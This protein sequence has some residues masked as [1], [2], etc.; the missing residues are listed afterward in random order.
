MENKRLCENCGK[1]IPDDFV[2]NLCWDCY[3]RLSQ[4]KEKIKEN[5]EKPK[6]APTNGKNGITEENYY[7]NPEAED[8]EQWEAN[9]SL[10][11]KNKIMLWKSTRQIYT[12][13]KNYNL[14]KII[15]H[16]QYPKFIWKPRIVD[17]GCGIGLG[18]NVLSQEADFVWG[19]DKNLNSI[20]FAKE[21]FERL[22]NNIYYSSQV[23][24][25]QIDIMTD[26][27]EFAQFDQVVAVEVIEHIYDYKGFIGALIRFDKKSYK[28]KPVSDATEY[29]LSTPNRNNRTIGDNRPRNK[30]HVREW[31]SAEIY[32]IMSEFFE[33]VELMNAIG[34]PIPKEEYETTTHTPLLIK[35]SM[36]K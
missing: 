21:C 1:E 2:N 26:T 8:K 23:T 25:E 5:L 30:Y 6:V 7:E 24:F 3:N 29:F 20:R 17:V 11:Q 28:G 4:V 27:R 32:N 14:E 22:K 15:N 19:I 18:S 13:I 16:P 12:Y 10:F 33:N 34:T 9:F 36:V 35:C 31:N